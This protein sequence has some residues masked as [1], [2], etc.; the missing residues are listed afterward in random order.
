MNNV[1]SY[2]A[3]IVNVNDALKPTLDIYRDA[4]SFLID[5]ANKEWADLELL[6]KKKQVN[7]IEKLTHKT[8]DNPSP[9]YEFDLLFYKF[10]SYL[11]RSAISDALGI[12]SSYQSNLINYNKE[13]YEAI[14]NGKKFKKK[15]PMLMKRHYKCPALYKGNMFEPIDR[16][17]YL[18]KIYKNNDWV[19]LKIKLRE[20]DI[21]YIEK[22]SFDKTFSPLLTKKGRSYYLQFSFEKKS[23]L[24][25]TKLKDQKVLAVDLGLNHSAVC[26]VVISDGTVIDRLFIN[27]PIEKDR[28]NHL[29]NR[30][31]LKRQQSGKY[32][33]LNKLWTK[34]NNLN[35][36]IVNKTVNSIINFAKLHNVD[37]IVFEYLDF[38]GKRPNKIA[39]KMQMWAKRLIQ[40]KV[41]D[42]AHIS[43]IRV[44]RINPYNTSALAFDGSGKVKRDDKNAKICTFTTGKI[45]NTDLNASYNI[46]SRYFIREYKKTISE[47][48]WSLVVAKVPEL[49]RRTQCT[50][51]T[52]ISLVAVL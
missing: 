12:V 36:E 47:K 21:K 19:W 26:S 46:A 6:T 43:G 41:E 13:R 49:M 9:K 10:P 51:S 7:F 33:K 23:K 25:N 24:N 30:Y 39:L 16:T 42:K 20:Q 44:N 35:T 17:T 31:K 4:V 52:L 29:L 27:Q 1:F 3:K 32:A 2:K 38:K 5:V 8:K 22:L 18:I 45:Y 37:V 28:Q 48:K 50:L 11:R 34:I 14:S 15:A 40:S